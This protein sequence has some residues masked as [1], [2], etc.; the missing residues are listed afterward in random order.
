MNL[1]TISLVRFDIIFTCMALLL[2]RLTRSEREMPKRRERGTPTNPNPDH[3]PKGCHKKFLDLLGALCIHK[4]MNLTKNLAESYVEIGIDPYDRILAEY[5]SI[6]DDAAEVISKLTYP[7]DSPGVLNLQGLS[8]ISSAAAGNLVRFEGSYILLGG[9]NSISLEVALELARFDGVGIDIG[10]VQ[11]LPDKLSQYE[12][13]FEL[14]SAWK[15]G[16]W[17]DCDDGLYFC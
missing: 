5:T 10:G 3:K 7:E 15:M 6:D 11:S 9:L 4:R 12:D 16:N 17:M 8:A 2:C 1:S 13:Q 14:L